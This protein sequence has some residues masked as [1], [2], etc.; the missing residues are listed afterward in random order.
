MNPKELI[1][2]LEE[3]QQ[4]L[5]EHERLWGKSLSHPIPD[6]PVANTSELKKQSQWLCRRLGNLRPFIER[7][8]TSW[9][10]HHPATGLAWDALDAVTG[11]DSVAQIKGPT[12]SA[13]TGKL[14]RIIGQVEALDQLDDIPLERNKPIKSGADIDQVVAKYLYHLHPYI[15][16]GCV[17]LFHVTA[18]QE[19]PSFRR[20]DCPTLRRL[21][22]PIPPCLQG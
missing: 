20:S 3:F 19:F 14:N 11:L 16:K 13:V 5:L 21:A 2:A 7:F 15:T 4:R 18:G 9:R 17:P 6:Y 12:F 22:I 10:M 8:D 1:E